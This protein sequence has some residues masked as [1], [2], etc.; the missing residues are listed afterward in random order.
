MDRAMR[1]MSAFCI[2]Q[3]EMEKLNLLI[4]EALADGPLSKTEL[5][6]LIMPVAKKNMQEWMGRVWNMFKSA[7]FEG[8]VCY[9]QNKG[10]EALFVRVDRWLPHLEAI[11]EDKAKQIMLRN[12]FKSYGPASLVD[13]SKWSGN[14][15]TESENIMRAVKDEFHEVNYDGKKGFI[16]TED[17]NELTPVKLLKNSLRLLPVFDSYILGHAGKDHLLNLKNYKKV[18]RNQGRISPVIL[19]DG[20]IIGIWSHKK[21]S[22]NYIIEIELFD[23][24]PKF[25][26]RKIE[27]EIERLESFWEYPCEI[28]FNR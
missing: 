27:K 6:K 28:K 24:F 23:K 22:K 11:S 13:F 15:V 1:I 3:K 7:I 10:N 16:L 20:R 18:Y 17:L 12:Y 19:L 21:K 26:L 4:L 25:I 9:A 8:L 14:L 2:K 5:T